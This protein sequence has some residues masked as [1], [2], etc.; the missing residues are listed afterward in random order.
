MCCTTW[1]DPSGRDCIEEAP[2]RPPDPAGTGRVCMLVASSCA[3]AVAVAATLTA[4]E[5]AKQRSD[6]C[7]KCMM[8]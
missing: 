1:Y 6:V 2:G 5:P 7:V 8:G 3:A 4:N